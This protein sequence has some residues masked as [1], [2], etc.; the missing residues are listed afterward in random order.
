MYGEINNYIW[1][2]RERRQWAFYYT[3]PQSFIMNFSY[4]L[5]I[6]VNCDLLVY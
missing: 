5:K 1:T 3:G 6:F 2:Q 4:F